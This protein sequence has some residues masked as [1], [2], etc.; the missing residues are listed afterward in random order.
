MSV[1]VKICGLK[2]E[3]AV[4]A[5]VAGG[6]AFAGFVFFEKSPRFLT[7]AAAGRLRAALPAHIPAVAVTVDADDDAI[8]AIVA[9]AAPDYLQLHGTENPARV[10]ALKARTGLKVIKAI[11]VA[12][13]GD[14]APVADFDKVAD[15]LLFDAKAGA[16]DGRPGGNARRFDWSLVAGVITRA[17]FLLAGGLNAVN[18]KDAVAQSG[19]RRVDV[20]SGVETAPGE[21]DP[22][23]I[24]AFLEAA[25]TI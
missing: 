6:A 24:A 3:A 19:A 10:A 13:P 25:K 23:L 21:K 7:P 9:G 18:L 22:K 8:D 16:D 5:A 2:S 15:L 17:P 14:L 12:G 11:P 20:S 4:T 1:S